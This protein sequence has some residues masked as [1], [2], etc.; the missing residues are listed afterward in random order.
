MFF[1]D[2]FDEEQLRTRSLYWL[3]LG[4]FGVLLVVLWNMQVAHGKS[5]QRDLMRQSVRRVRLPGLRGRMFDRAGACVADNRPSY[6]IAVYLEELRRPGRWSRTIDRVESCIRELSAI[7]DRPAEVSREDIRI[8]TRKRLPLP[9]LA[10]RDVDEAALARLAERAG[11]MPGVDVHVEAVRFYPFGVSACHLLGYVGRA[12]PPEQGDEPYHYYIPEMAGRSGVERSYDGVLR[13]ASGGRLVRVDVSGFRHDDLALREP[14]RGHDLRLALDMRV[15]RL[16][17]EALGEDR[18]AGVVIDPS[19]GDVLAMA[20][21]PGFDLNAFVPAISVARWDEMRGDEGKPLLNRAAAG[22]YAPGSTFKPVVAVAALESGRA[23]PQTSFTC[24]GYFN[25]GRARF[26]C[27]YHPGHGT[28]E[29]QQGLEHSCNVYFFR[30]ALLCGYEPIYHMAA[31]LGLGKKTDISLEYEATG[32][33]PDDGWKRRFYGDG[34]RDGDTCNVAIGQGPL[35]VTPLQMALLAATLANGGRLFTP[36]LVTAVLDG[37]GEVVREIPPRVA[38]ELHWS[39]RTVRTVR[40]GMKDVVMSPRGTGRLAGVPGVTMAGKT[41][42]AEYGRKDEGK[43]LAW[44]IAFA[45]YDNPRYAVALVV[46]E[47]ATGGTTAAPRMKKIMTGL[48][49]DDAVRKGQ[50]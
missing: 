27:W 2:L 3:M 37:N 50:G 47:G 41:G 21:S 24:P 49:K 23:T 30:L 29:M 26:N 7:L 18:G 8:H 28:L 5:Y 19:N 40:E 16:I 39:A 9:L 42:T 17:E 25:L 13:G 14:H 12:D 4:V 38:N 45:P 43:R 1:R 35:L 46:E 34:W 10:W 36:R 15:Q 6:D 20:S 32:L 11:T 31:A 44:M 48:F 33:L 22:T